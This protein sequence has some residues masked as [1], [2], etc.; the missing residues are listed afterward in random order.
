MNA[1]IVTKT[2]KEKLRLT[3]TVWMWYHDINAKIR[4]TF[5]PVLC[6]LIILL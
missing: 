5:E 4:M 3:E 1:G 6:D 2:V